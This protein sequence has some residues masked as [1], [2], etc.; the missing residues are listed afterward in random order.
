MDNI[1]Y[2][3]NSDKNIQTDVKDI[4]INTMSVFNE[5][6]YDILRK[7]FEMV[8]PQSM[9]YQKKER[10]TLPYS[11]LLNQLT[12]QQGEHS[13]HHIKQH[14]QQII[15]SVAQIYE[16]LCILH[17][18]G[19]HFDLHVFGSNIRQLL[20][21]KPVLSQNLDIAIV[22][23][24]FD[25]YG[26]LKEFKMPNYKTLETRLGFSTEHIENWFAKKKGGRNHKFYQ[27]NNFQKGTYLVE[28]LLSPWFKQSE[29]KTN[30]PRYRDDDFPAY[31]SL[32]H[33]MSQG[34]NGMIELHYP[35][36]KNNVILDDKH[37]IFQTMQA[38]DL[39]TF[40]FKHVNIH[41]APSWSEF[42]KRFD[43]SLSHV[44]ARLVSAKHTE[45]SL[46]YFPDNIKDF[47]Q[48]L[49]FSSDCLQDIKNHTISMNYTYATFE[50][51]KQTLSQYADR[52]RAS[53]PDD[54]SWT[55]N[56]ELNKLTKTEHELYDEIN[57]QKKKLIDS[58]LLKDKIQE[59][60]AWRD[61]EEENSSDFTG[62]L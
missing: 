8:L 31:F 42:Q 59:Q 35:Q 27:L 15:Q 32:P 20:T 38:L 11:D 18:C 48:C 58:F 7:Q 23:K 14:I 13:P 45:N 17:S 62:K 10:Y 33:H 30:R 24:K 16:K 5:N 26:Q 52:F 37:A 9:Q 25:N 19:I 57:A 61:N 21:E 6:H 55:W 36:E 40:A 34:L 2:L 51:I 29:F 44:Q 41:I 4:D 22:F 49:N 43:F 56:F 50:S 3:N 46:F 47:Y 39:D 28:Y 60:W 54:F 1:I 53:L 12:W